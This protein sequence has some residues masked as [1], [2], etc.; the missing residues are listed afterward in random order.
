MS[1]SPASAPRAAQS[2]AIHWVEDRRLALLRYRLNHPADGGGVRAEFAGN[3]FRRGVP[4]PPVGRVHQHVDG[5]LH[6]HG[7]ALPSGHQGFHYPR[8][9]VLGELPDG[10][11]VGWSGCGLERPTHTRSVIAMGAGCPS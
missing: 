7:D 9:Q 11:N 1:F 2:I 10:T 8:A 4:V 5:L 3:R 6:R